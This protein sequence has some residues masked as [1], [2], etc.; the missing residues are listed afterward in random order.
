MTT[1]KELKEWLN[2]FPEDTIIEVGIQ[3][4]AGNYEAYGAVKF[5]SPKLEDNDSGKGWEFTDFRNNQFVKE[6]A[7]YYR[8][9]YLKFGEAS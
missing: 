4:R 7:P 8:K 3:E 9:C 5:E 6:D 2:R 1:I